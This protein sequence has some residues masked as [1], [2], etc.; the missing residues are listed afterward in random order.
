MSRNACDCLLGPEVGEPR[1]PL[2]LLEAADP[3]ARDE[4]PDARAEVVDVLLGQ[5]QDVGGVGIAHKQLDVLDRSGEPGGHDDRR[6]ACAGDL[7]STGLDEVL[8]GV[9]AAAD[10]DALHRVG[11]VAVETREEAEAVLT[12]QVRPAVRAG[13]PLDHAPRLAARQRLALEDANLEAA[14]DQLMGRA[15]PG[16]AAA[17]DDDR[18]HSVRYSLLPELRWATG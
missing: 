13:V 10:R 2:V 5:T 4:L 3:T 14:L 18:C 9:P 12:G 17:E 11:H 7:V 6:P 8:V 16:H 15:H 1:Q